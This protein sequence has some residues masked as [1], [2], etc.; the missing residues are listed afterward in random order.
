MC[1]TL[2]SYTGL[3]KPLIAFNGASRHIENVDLLLSFK[4]IFLE[5]NTV[6]DIE[7][8]PHHE[9]DFITLRLEGFS[10]LELQDIHY[11]RWLWM[12]DK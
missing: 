11:A 7:F 4:V 12:Y 3:F 8:R 2:E 1:Y 5:D 6:D 10:R 9:N